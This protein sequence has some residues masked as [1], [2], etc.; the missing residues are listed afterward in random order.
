MS[1]EATRISTNKETARLNHLVDQLRRTWH[2]HVRQLFILVIGKCSIRK[3]KMFK[4]IY[5]RKS[6]HQPRYSRLLCLRCNFPFRWTRRAD[7]QPAVQQHRDTHS[8]VQQQHWDE[9][10]PVVPIRLQ[11]K[12]DNDQQGDQ[13]FRVHHKMLLPGV[14]NGFS[15]PS[16]QNFV[17]CLLSWQENVCCVSLLDKISNISGDETPR[18]LLLYALQCFF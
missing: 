3:I 18:L 17:L 11:S 12:G 15:L 8:V 13:V 10:H 1:K 7:A 14:G 9:A 6:F 5:G 4:S 2:D 16:R